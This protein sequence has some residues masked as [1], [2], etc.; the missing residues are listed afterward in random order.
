MI[1]SSA[2]T[3][4]PAPASDAQG[5]GDEIDMGALEQIAR[6]AFAGLPA[7]FTNST[8]LADTPPLGDEAT[9]PAPDDIASVQGTAIQAPTG[10]AIGSEA[11]SSPVLAVEPAGAAVQPSVLNPDFTLPLAPGGE[12]PESS[13]LHRI[14][15]D[16]WTQAITLG[17]PAVDTLTIPGLS[18]VPNYLA[19]ASPDARA[20][21][22]SQIEALNRQLSEELGRL[23]PLDGG[24]AGAAVPISADGHVIEESKPASDDESTLYFL[25]SDVAVSKG[26]GGA[27]GFDVGAVRKDFPALDQEVNGKPLVWLDNAATTQKPAGVI[28]ALKRFYECDNSNV[29]RGAHTLAARATEAYEEARRRVQHF[30]GAGDSREI[31]F[32]RGATEAI[33]LVAQTYGRRH[34]GPG[35]EI[36]V[37][38][39]EHHSN[40][41]PWQLLAQDRGAILRVVPIDDHGDVILEEYEKLLGARTK[42]VAL[43][44]VSNAL[45]TVLPARTM[46][47]M[48]HRYNARV[49]VDGAQAVP[50]Q[51]VD[52]KE[53]DADFYAFSGHK[54][55]GPTGI[56]VL[57]GKADLLEF[58]PPWQGG[59]NM[60]DRV[61]FERTT[62]SGLPNKFEAGTGS[63]ADAV[64]LGAA[65][66]YLEK[67][68]MEALLRHER[69]LMSYATAAL[70]T[71]PGLRQIGT[72]VDKVS[73]LSF[74]LAGITNEDLG[75]FLDKEGIAVRSGHHCAQPTMDRYGV[76]GTVRPSLAFYNTCGEIDVLVNAI[77]KARHRLR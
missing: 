70:C 42:I 9:K 55:F 16:V 2:G 62:Y 74:V 59:G 21:E 63:I 7:N 29:H 48:A 12:I 46:I 49:L 44:H 28:A 39:L 4:P 8:G 73:V 13:V 17:E 54:L 26:L 19:G 47:E 51:K 69:A 41:V 66:D 43:S 32:V 15:S 45:G 40:I 35:D 30:L 10:D 23:F 57:Y 27:D 38:T 36:V 61:T 65:I 14:S 31:V 68:G 77:E 22:T 76:A 24:T 34:V 50:H 33:N 60:I 67:L 56:G 64:G 25:P 11:I 18:V 72:S 75:N 3:A 37:T 53:L 5:R 58:M 52:V 20:L 1:T 71:I 6:F